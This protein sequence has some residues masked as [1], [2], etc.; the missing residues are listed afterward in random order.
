PPVGQGAQPLM[1]WLRRG[2]ETAPASAPSPGTPGE[3]SGSSDRPRAGRGEGSLKSDISNFK[4][5]I[6][7]LKSQRAT[8]FIDPTTLMRIKSLEL[9]ARI[10]VQGFLS[11]LHRSPHHGFSVELSEY[12]QYSRSDHPPYLVSPLI[13]RS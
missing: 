9:R 11:G 7:N 12:S 10:V 13:P 2:R 8:S 1:P 3:A 6:S 5:E 4:S